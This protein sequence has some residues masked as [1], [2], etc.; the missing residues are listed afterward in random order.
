MTEWR[1]GRGGAGLP[2]ATNP[3]E[4]GKEIGTRKRDLEEAMG[5]VEVGQQQRL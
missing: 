2:A 3:R 5:A 1:K 4:G